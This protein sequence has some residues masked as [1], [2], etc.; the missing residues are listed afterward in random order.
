M[1]HGILLAHDAQRTELDEHRHGTPVGCGERAQSAGASG[2]TMAKWKALLFIAIV[3]GMCSIALLG[4]FL[5]IALAVLAVVAGAT[6]YTWEAVRRGAG[7]VGAALKGVG[8][9]ENCGF[10]P[11][12]AENARFS[13]EKPQK[14]VA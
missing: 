4:I 6:L 1:V 9:E 13:A 5:V 12:S 11:S 7:V 14:T 8:D 2:H 3:P 10:V